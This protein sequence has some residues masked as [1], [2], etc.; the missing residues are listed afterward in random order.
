MFKISQFQEL[1]KGLPRGTFDRLIAQHQ[2]NK[3]SKGFGCWEQLL[4]MIYGQLSG[5]SSLRQL[6]TGFN[7]HLAHHYH[8]GAKPV[9]RSTLAEANSKRSEGLFGDA[10]RLLMSNV[11]RRLRRESTELL[12]LLD[13]T[14]IIL[15]GLGFDEWTWVSRTQ[16]TQGMKLHMIYA[17]HSEVPVWH[18]FSTPTVNDVAK[19]GEF[20]ISA[21]A[22]YVFDKGYCDYNWWHNIDVQGAQFVTRFK[23]NAALKVQQELPIPSDVKE[24]IL[25]DQ[26]VRFSNKHPGG[27]RINQYRKP[28]RRIQVAREG[29]PALILATNDL[30]TPA[31]EVAQRYKQRWKIELFFKWIKQHLKIKRF[32]GRSENA[33]RIQ[34]LT[35]LISYLLVSLY[36]YRH[37]LKQ[38]L[39]EC[40]CLIRATLFQRPTLE[41]LL[42][43]KRCQQL[44]QLST[45]QRPLFS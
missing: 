27:G 25:S 11:S 40:L 33:V 2:A 28:L 24:I 17:A 4:A 35:A 23:R 38:S 3:Y 19:V 16:R 5:A 29:K 43:R 10:A 45:M 18:S 22:L 21:G 26:I 31:I 6:Q 36:K 30:N 9:K 12:Y 42:H 8:L 39:W 13:S 34:I 37:G 32:F 41:L 1:M 7:S 15:K 14:P 44:K 20:S